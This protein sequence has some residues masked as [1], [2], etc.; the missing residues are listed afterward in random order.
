MVFKLIDTEDR[1]KLSEG[2]NYGFGS[3]FAKLEGDTFTTVCPITA[4]KDFLNE[5]V[6]TEAHGKAYN[7]Y[8]LNYQKTN[9]F[10][11]EK[12]VAYIVAAILP[13]NR[14]AN[15][16]AFDKDL[17]AL[18]ANYKNME[19][20]LNW[21]E[22]KFKV[23]RKTKI[24]KIAENRYLFQ[25]PLFWTKGTYL[26]SLYAYLS[27]ASIYFDKTKE[28]LKY[29]DEMNNT[30]TY[31]WNSMKAKVLDMIDGFIPQ[32]EMK[33]TDPCPHSNGIVSFKW[34]RELKKIESL[35]VGITK[36]IKKATICT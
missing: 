8:G 23:K 30:G 10:D 21:F 22:K 15:Y 16:P 5:V 28:P 26:I 6:A 19:Y 12:G 13:Y 31:M 1:G 20:F 29:L 27:R 18:N 4:C 7:I 25:L 9:C 11:A 32:Q 14:G 33:E 24:T 17:V 34:P 3:G 2:R 36:E 35:K